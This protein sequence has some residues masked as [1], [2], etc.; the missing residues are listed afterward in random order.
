MMGERIKTTGFLR[1]IPAAV[2]MIVIYWLSDRP[3]TESSVQSGG[4][5]M[6]IVNLM[7]QSSGLNDAQQMER[8]LYLEP[9]IR[10][11]AH[12]LEY[13]ILAVLV[14]IAVRAF[15]SDCGRAA[16]ITVLVCFL[17]ACTDEWHQ[18]YIPGRAAE[19]MDIMLDTSGAAAA[20]LIYS[21][22]TVMI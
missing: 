4:L 2:W 20:M 5:T 10:E 3:S 9:Y 6:R 7:T 14:L 17:Y 8:T 19:Y 15:T 1:L 13:V 11:A 18:Y 22:R 21:I 12:V 16:L